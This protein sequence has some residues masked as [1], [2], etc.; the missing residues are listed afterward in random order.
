MNQECSIVRDLLPLYAERLT[1]PETAAFVEKHLRTCAD[2]R[3]A[4]QETQAPPLQHLQKRLARKRLQIIVMT[5][6]FV[7]TAVISAAGILNAPIYFPYTDDL[8]Q[9]TEDAGALELTFRA[10]VANVTTERFVDPDDPLREICLVSI[11][12]TTA[13]RPF[14]SR[15]SRWPPAA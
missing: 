10:D 9:V 7:L 12:K 13:R 3:A 5:A 15:E 2:C 1:S 14:I 11:A 6:L 4:L 8:V